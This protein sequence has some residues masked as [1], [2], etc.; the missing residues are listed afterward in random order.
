LGKFWTLCVFEPSLGGLGTTYDVHLGLIV[1]CIV[2]LLLV[3]IEL[4]SLG[5]TA[6]TLQVKIDNKSDPKIFLQTVIRISCICL[7]FDRKIVQTAAQMRPVSNVFT[8]DGP[9]VRL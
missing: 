8:R 6:E 4:F 2:D 1:K 7:V 5:V 3:S 9:N